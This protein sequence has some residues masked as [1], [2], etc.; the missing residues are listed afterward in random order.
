MSI[1]ELHSKL[2]QKMADLFKLSDEL[3]KEGFNQDYTQCRTK[4]KLKYKKFKDKL[5]N[6]AAR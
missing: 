5:V 1:A 2:G 3:K 6:T 4:L